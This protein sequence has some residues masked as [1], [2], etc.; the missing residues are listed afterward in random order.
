VRST[1]ILAEGDEREIT[2]G[3][4]DIA[5]ET[6]WTSVRDHGDPFQRIEAFNRGRTH[7]PVA[8]L[9]SA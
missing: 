2:N 1:L 9:P 5:D 7:G 3:L 8:C 4:T 6:E